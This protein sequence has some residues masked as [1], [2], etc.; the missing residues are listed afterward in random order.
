MGTSVVE[1]VP[2]LR[3]EQGLGFHMSGVGVW[4]PLL[5]GKGPSELEG[6]WSRSHSTLG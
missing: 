2:K 4:V 1:E 5:R 3:A 6:I